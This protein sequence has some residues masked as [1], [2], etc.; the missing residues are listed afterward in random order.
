MTSLG[1]LA[2]HGHTT[3]GELDLLYCSCWLGEGRRWEILGH[4]LPAQRRTGS[5]ANP[6][7]VCRP[8]VAPLATPVSLARIAAD[9][10]SHDEAAQTTC[11]RCLCRSERIRANRDTIAVSR[12]HL[13]HLTRARGRYRRRR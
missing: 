3:F 6:E 5:I 9:F 11:E 13:R 4:S 8:L 1:T 2:Q 10:L 7:T 12:T